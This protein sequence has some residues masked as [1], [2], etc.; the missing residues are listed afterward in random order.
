MPNHIRLWENYDPKIC[1][2]VQNYMFPCLQYLAWILRNLL[3]SLY[4]FA[5]PL[6]AVK[7]LG[8]SQKQLGW[9]ESG[10]TFGL[11]WY[12][13]EKRESEAP[14]WA[15]AVRSSWLQTLSQSTSPY[16]WSRLVFASL[17]SENQ[18]WITR[19]DRAILP[20]DPQQ[21]GSRH[22]AVRERVPGACSLRAGE[23]QG[24]S[25][26]GVRGGHQEFWSN[27]N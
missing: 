2:F 7:H 17:I 21:S 3:F 18:L 24:R 12:L 5:L 22:P 15:S 1:L 13:P 9:E 26:R 8:S 20:Q 16:S 19:I 23:Q 14:A 11:C 4:L 6:L 27:H 25:F 10:T